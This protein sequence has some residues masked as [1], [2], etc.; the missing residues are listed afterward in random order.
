MAWGGRGV[1]FRRLDLPGRLAAMAG[2]DGGW[3]VHQRRGG[4]GG[5]SGRPRCGSAARRSSGRSAVVAPWAGGVR[6]VGSGHCPVWSLQCLGAA[7]LAPHGRRA[8]A[9]A[10]A[11]H[12]RAPLPGPDAGHGPHGNDDARAGDNGAARDAAGAGRIHR[13]TGG[14]QHHRCRRRGGRHHSRARTVVGLRRRRP[15][16]RRAQPVVCPRRLADP[17]T[18]RL[19]RASCGRRT[20]HRGLRTADRGPRT[21]YPGWC[22]RRLRVP[23]GSPTNWSRTACSTMP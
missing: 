9:R 7:R 2:P 5:V 3:H 22:M 23:Q 17:P 14:R 19:R 6:A 8:R 11:D 1:R 18:P 12:V 4:G 15:V 16:R 10:P 21:I 20:A 13:T